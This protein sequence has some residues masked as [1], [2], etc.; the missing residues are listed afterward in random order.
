M[1]WCMLGNEK[2]DNGTIR[3]AGRAI[4]AQEAPFIIAEMSGNHN[5]SLER[6]LS[7]VDAAA[8][9][10]ACA[11]KLQTYTAD[12][13]TLDLAEGDF[14]IENPLSPWKGESLYSLYE[15]AHTPWEWHAPI[16][17]HCREQ[18]LIA[19]SSPFDA[20]AV[21]FLEKLEA[22]AYKIASFEILD[23]PLIRKVAATGKPVIISTGM[24]S[25]A[26]ID[27]AV[28]AARQAGCH[29]LILLKC[30]SSYPA[31][32]ADSHLRSLPYLQQRFATP[33]GLSDHTPG[34]GAA[35]AAVALGA[36]VIEKHLTLSRAEGG[37]DAA[38]S[39]EPDE[40]AQLVEESRMAQRALGQV[41]IG[42]CE[43]ERGSL[44]FRRTLYV[45]EDIPA[46]TVFSTKNIRAIRPGFGLPPRHYEAVLGQKSACPIRK[47]TPLSFDLIAESHLL[48]KP[49]SIS[50]KPKIPEMQNQ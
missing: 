10:G 49:H 44:Q 9:A 39:L 31:N 21:D 12:T 14:F 20:S 2:P 23:L 16:F 38:F 41:H 5:G 6:A 25:E 28:T 22:P 17:K 37:V 36:V 42:P 47:G 34:I 19:F 26:E 8:D 46:G 7:I 18:G 40:L 33:V 50:V 48:E 11:I 32:P 24:A 13:M 43:H 30:T 45:V 15:K 27:E 35:L 29:E 1:W 4:G 3:I